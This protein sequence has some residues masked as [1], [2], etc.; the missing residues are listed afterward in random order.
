MATYL[1]ELHELFPNGLHASV[2]SNDRNDRELEA[3]AVANLNRRS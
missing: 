3:V 1:E 2:P